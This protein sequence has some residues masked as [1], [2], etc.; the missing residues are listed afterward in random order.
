MLLANDWSIRLCDFGLSIFTTSKRIHV[1]DS[2]AGT[3]A[4]ASPEQMMGNL[5]D[6]K[7]DVW[8]VGVILY[9]LC[10]LIPP[11]G[12]LN[13]RAGPIAGK[14]ST[15]ETHQFHALRKRILF[16]SYPALP[17]HFGYVTNLTIAI[18]LSLL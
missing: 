12:D 16:G 9:M 4:Y 13:A 3:P 7:T 6:T 14:M 18:L 11:F 15:D 10:A 17:P 1:K 2:F 5:P 8:A